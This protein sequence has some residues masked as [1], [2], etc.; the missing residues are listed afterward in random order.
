MFTVH[1]ALQK[2]AMKERPVTLSGALRVAALVCILGS[3]PVALLKYPWLPAMVKEFSQLLHDPAP[4]GTASYHEYRA[5]RLERVE[6]A[7]LLYA[8]GSVS[9][10]GL[11]AM[12]ANLLPWWADLAGWLVAALTGAGVVWFDRVDVAPGTDP[13]YILLTVYLPLGVAAIATIAVIALAGSRL[14]RSSWFGAAR[15]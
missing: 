8:L 10:G 4:G 5:Q 7:L 12:V 1:P 3:A 11:G 13:A 6:F 14:V 9:L 15:R 2:P